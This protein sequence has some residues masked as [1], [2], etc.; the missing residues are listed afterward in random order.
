MDA[1]NNF[2][3]LI[4]GL[5]SLIIVLAIMSVAAL[6]IFPEETEP[7]LKLIIAPTRLFEDELQFTFQSTTSGVSISIKPYVNIEYVDFRI[8][9]LDK[10]D[11]IIKTQIITY[12]DLRANQTYQFNA[13][14]SLSDRLSAHSVRVVFDTGKK[15]WVR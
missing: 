10:N 8:E 15:I 14:L 12:E 9:L 13:S 4:G 7:I 1:L 2:I 6:F 3:K 5:I 11:V